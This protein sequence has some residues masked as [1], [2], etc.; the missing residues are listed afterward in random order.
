M[1]IVKY[2]LLVIATFVLL[3]S[4][5]SID[6]IWQQDSVLFVSEFSDSLVD[7]DLLT[8]N[9]LMIYLI[10]MGLCAAYS[11]IGLLR[12]Q[13]YA[14]YLFL[15]IFVFMIPV[16]LVLGITIQSGLSRILYDAGLLMSGILLTLVFTHP[17]KYYFTP[18]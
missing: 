1:S 9:L 7:L 2:R 5:V 15:A 17:V 6:L 13:S 11:F 14:R 3:F 8:N 10:V 18:S 4:S 12:L 16:Y